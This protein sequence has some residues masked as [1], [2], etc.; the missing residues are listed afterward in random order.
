MKVHNKIVPAEERE[1]RTKKKKKQ[2]KKDGEEKIE[3]INTG[4]PSL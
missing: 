1:S 2:K 3:E 4:W